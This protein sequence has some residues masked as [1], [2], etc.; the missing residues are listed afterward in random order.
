[1]RVEYYYDFSNQMEK[2]FSGLTFDVDDVPMV[3]YGGKIGLR[4]NPVTIAQYSLANHSLYL[5]T[6]DEKY[7]KI[8]LKC[9]NWFLMFISDYKNNSA[10]WFYNFDLMECGLKAPWISAMA[11]GLAMSVLV[12]ANKLFGDKNYMDIAEKAINVFDVPVSEEGVMSFFPD[13]GIVFEEYPTG[14][15]NSVL[16]G[17]IFTIFGLYDLYTFTGNKKAEMLFNKAIN[18]LKNNIERYDTNY[19]TRYDLRNDKRLAS[20]EY[21]ILH[22]KLLGGLYE[23]TND[24]YFIEMR[25][26]WNGYYRSLF[27][28]IR[29][30]IIKFIQ[31]IFKL[32]YF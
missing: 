7:L 16:N 13:G 17:L 27:C 11:Q 21:H 22:I 10:V 23:I 14:F 28:K 25:N 15:S 4:Y 8:F 1:M 31:K 18:S 3:N 26:K 19:W 2:Y 29:F 6:K 32:K 30:G 9:V 12:R 24:T 5:Q 20:V